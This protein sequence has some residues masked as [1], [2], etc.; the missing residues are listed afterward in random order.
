[1]LTGVTKDVDQRQLHRYFSELLTEGEE[2]E[3]EVIKLLEGGGIAY[4]TFPSVDM[5]KKILE[6]L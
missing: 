2:N 3:L 6:V 4:V 5:A 1:M